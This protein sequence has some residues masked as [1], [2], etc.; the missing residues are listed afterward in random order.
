MTALAGHP[1]FYYFRYS[2]LYWFIKIFQTLFV[3]ILFLVPVLQKSQYVILRKLEYY[4]K[5]ESDKNKELTTVSSAN[6]RAAVIAKTNE[7]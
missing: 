5:G 7:K 2:S 1:L 3:N 4:S 6:G